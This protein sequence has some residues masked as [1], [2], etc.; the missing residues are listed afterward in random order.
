MTG[1]RIGISVS[2]LA[3]CLFSLG[4]ALAADKVKGKGVITLRSGSTL[5][6]ETDQGTTTVTVTPDTK[7]QH[8]I[9]LGARKKQVG[10]EVLIPGLKLKFEGT[11]DQNQVTAE[12]ITFDQDDLSLAKVIQAGLNPTAQQQA[13]NIEAYQA[14]KQSTDAELAANRAAIAAHQREID[15]TKQSVA[16]NQQ[17]IQ[18]VA[19]ST[20]RRFSDLATWYVKGEATVRFEVG[21]S[22]L[23]EEN[24]Q[25][26]KALANQA[27]SYTGFVIEVRG[28]ADSTGRLE[29]NQQLSK[30]R[31]QAVVAYLLQD[32]NVPTKN[33]AAPGAMGETN[34]PASNETAYG[35][36]ENRRVDLKLLVNKGVAGE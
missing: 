14:N 19:Q 11:G 12:T 36:A 35:R 2:L 15:A 21:D 7:V 27:L 1:R 13:R 5:T 9:G 30:E 26:I 31:A 34:P 8:P 28:Y 18:E 33:I 29:D 16:A 17:G 20:S 6:V 24:K 25:Q 23:S 22:A 10:Q 4:S 3:V 32:C